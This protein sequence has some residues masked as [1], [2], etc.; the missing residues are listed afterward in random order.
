M[1]AQTAVTLVGRESAG[2]LVAPVVVVYGGLMV[3]HPVMLPIPDLPVSGL[4]DQVR[5]AYEDRLGIA[6][7]A[8]Y[9]ADWA[10]V[11]YLAARA[12][13]SGSIIDVGA[14]A[15]QLVNM[16]ALSGQY[17]RV[18]SLDRVR[19]DHWC[20]L[21]ERIEEQRGDISQLDHPDGA[22]D[23]VICAEV[24]EH[25]PD[26]VFEAALSELRRICRGQ[27]LMTVPYREPEPLYHSHLRRFEDE[28]IEHLFPDAHITLLGG[29]KKPWAIIEE[30]CDGS[31]FG[32]DVDT[33]PLMRMVTE[34]A[35]R[36]RGLRRD[37]DRAEAALTRYRSFPP[38]RL[39]R[40]LRR[41]LRVRSG[42]RG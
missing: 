28:D 7:G 11:T 42:R 38:V 9:P 41:R 37:L 30:R 6:G 4:A 13:T 20:L 2:R 24:L 5:N 14:G 12:R 32:P 23:V 29:I 22:F 17:D 18:V 26:G 40:G 33:A 3:Y 39:V 19:N 35:A 1:N 36:Q 27:L 15:G 8:F 25:L 34:S 10:R 31:E 16:L 21:D